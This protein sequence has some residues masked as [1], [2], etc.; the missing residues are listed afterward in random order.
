MKIYIYKITNNIN[1][2]IYVGKHIDRSNNEIDNYMGSGITL[3]KAK[4]SME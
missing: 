1:G 4:K 2:K 3:K